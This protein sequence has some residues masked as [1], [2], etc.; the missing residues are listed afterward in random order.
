MASPGPLRVERWNLD[1][2]SI[3]NDLVML[4]GVLHA[5][6]H[7]ERASVLFCLSGPLTRGHRVLPSVN[8]GTR[9]VLLARM[10]GR[11]ALAALAAS[12]CSP[13]WAHG[14]DEPPWGFFAI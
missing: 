9:R 4:R 10:A 1:A 8:G 5:R 3:D 13:G 7:P 14:F 12:T 6:V 2:R 11:I